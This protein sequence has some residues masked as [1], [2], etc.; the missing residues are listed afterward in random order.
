MTFRLKALV[1][2]V[3]ASAVF[4]LYSSVGHI[5]EQWLHFFV[6]LAAV[7]LSSGMKVGI[8]KSEGTMSV[9]FPFI[10]LGIL[11]LSP[12]QAVGLAVCSVFAQ[13]RIR[14]VKP[15]TAVQIAFNLANV[16]TA[17]VAAWQVHL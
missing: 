6:Y 8:P 12:L 4:S 14:V 3:I 13:C 7:L 10:L 11:Q 1:C 2:L 16:I 15:F 17:T 5:S 9:N